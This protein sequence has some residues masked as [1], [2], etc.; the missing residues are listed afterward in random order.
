MGNRSSFRGVKR[1]GREADHA[2][3]SS[4]EIKESLELHLHNSNTP[5]WRGAHL[6]H[7]DNFVFTFLLCLSL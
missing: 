4:S 6:N 1:Q 2:S 5:S 3:P 7:T